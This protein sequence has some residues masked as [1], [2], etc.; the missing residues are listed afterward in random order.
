MSKAVLTITVA[1]VDG[2][3]AGSAVAGIVFTATGVANPTPLTQA[4]AP[5]ATEATFD[6]LAPDTWTFTALPVDANGKPLTAPG[7]SAPT[8]SLTIAAPTT[9]TLT[10]PTGITGT[11]A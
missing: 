9:V 5:T 8:V 2:F 11:A 1:P 3:A 6:N 4:V 10:V 7:Y